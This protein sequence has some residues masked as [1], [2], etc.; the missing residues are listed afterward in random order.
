MCACGGGQVVLGH[1]DLGAGVTGNCELPN[2]ES[3]ETKSS[4]MQEQQA[5]LTT[6][7]VLH[8]ILKFLNN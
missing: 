5:P 2:F 7:P 1:L 6:K 8:P 3:C 4:P